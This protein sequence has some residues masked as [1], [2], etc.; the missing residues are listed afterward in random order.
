MLDVNMRNHVLSGQT[1]CACAA[2]FSMTPCH[3]LK[4]C[5]ALTSSTCNCR[6]TVLHV[7]FGFPSVVFWP[8]TSPFHKVLSGCAFSKALVPVI[9]DPV[10]LEFLFSFN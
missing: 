2:Y 3:G 7:L 5:L 10:Y 8:I 6:M 1:T 4:P 9:K